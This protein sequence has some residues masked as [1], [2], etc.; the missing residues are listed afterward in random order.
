MNKLND[1]AVIG[2]GS[3]GT[4]LVKIFLE[5]T[6]KLNWFIRDSELIENIQL[7]K[8][9]TKYLRH[10]QLDIKKITMYS[11]IEE[12][13]DSSP[14]KCFCNSPVTCWPSLFRGSNIV[15]TTALSCRL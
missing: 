1:I 9:N 3:W 8:R 11:K 7:K 14:E 4:A 5:N 15:L 12:I 10:V 6:E 2:G 13:I